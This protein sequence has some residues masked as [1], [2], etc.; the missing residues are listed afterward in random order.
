ME[1]EDDDKDIDYD[2][3]VVPAVKNK[4]RYNKSPEEID[5]ENE[6]KYNKEIAPLKEV[7]KD[8]FEKY[9]ILIDFIEEEG[10]KE[11]LSKET[12]YRKKGLE[13]LTQKLPDIFKSSDKQDMAKTSKK[14]DILEMNIIRLKEKNK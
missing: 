11:I 3:R 8:D 12:D 2:E 9:E 1:I 4:N 7:K 13:L 5:Q 14:I 10:L 6:K